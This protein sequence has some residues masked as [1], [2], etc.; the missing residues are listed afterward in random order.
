[1]SSSKANRRVLKQDG[2]DWDQEEMATIGPCLPPIKRVCRRCGQTYVRNK[3]GRG[4][5][6]VFPC[7]VWVVRAVL[8]S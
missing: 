8:E 3:R 5:K 2:H 7:D 6:K 1:M 4:A